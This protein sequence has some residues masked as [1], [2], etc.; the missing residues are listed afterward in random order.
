MKFHQLF[1]SDKPIIGMVHLPPL[2]GSPKYEGKMDTIIQQAIN[3]AETLNQADFDG[4]IV[5][6]FGDVPYHTGAGPLERS[7]AFTR[8][9]NEI[10]RLVNV[11][12]GV[13]IQFN[14]YE[15]EVIIAGICDAD[16]IRVEAFVDNLATA[17]GI[18]TACSAQVQRII[19]RLRLPDFAIFA[20]VFVKEASVIG[21]TCIEDSIR[22]A[23][24]ASAD[25]II[26]TGVATGQKTPLDTVTKAKQISSL[27]ILVGSGFDKTQAQAILAV[28]DGAI[29]GSSIKSNGNAFNAVDPIA[30][31]ALIRTVR[32]FA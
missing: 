11:P 1:T 12:L 27:P 15:A 14:D 6:N 10:R 7:V 16:F 9:F 13:N 30:A 8:V 4:M 29:V 23:E 3:D 24:K 21:A 25:A 20:D 22:N 5:E 28:A 26:I 32:G 2:P 31:R 18:S 17:G 19:S